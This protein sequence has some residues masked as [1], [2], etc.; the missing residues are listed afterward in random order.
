VTEPITEL[1]ARA[2]LE[3]DTLPVPALDGVRA[4]GR[5]LRT[6]RRALPVMAAAAATLIVVA[7]SRWDASGAGGQLPAGPTD[8]SSSTATVG[9]TATP[10]S[11]ALRRDG[12]LELAD[13]GAGGW[14]RGADSGD[15]G[16]TSGA[17]L[18][19]CS[20]G[21]TG[22]TGGTGATASAPGVGRHQ[23]FRGST[24]EGAEWLV[25]EQ[26]VTVT[27]A[28]VPALGAQFAAVASG[29]RTIVGG[30]VVLAADGHL[31]VTGTLLPTGSVG[32]AHGYALAGSTWV[33]LETLPGGAIGQIPLP[34]QAQWLVDITAKAL[35]R[36]TGRP[37]ETVPTPNAAA[38]AAAAKYVSPTAVIHV[39]SG[40]ASPLPVTT[41]IA[42]PGP[43][44]AASGAGGL[45]KGYLRLADLGTRGGWSAAPNDPTDRQTSAATAVSLPGCA[46]A[47][48]RGA[49]PSPSVTGPGGSLIYRGSTT[50]GSGEWI[51]NETVVRLGA[52]ATA[53]ARAQLAAVAGCST[54]SGGFGAG[55]RERATATSMVVGI[56]LADGSTGYAQAWALRGSV[57]VQLDTL[58]GGAA[59][60]APLPGGAPWLEG[61]LDT[62]LA[63]A[64]A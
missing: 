45:P 51:L 54:P 18:P 61:V 37:P 15:S 57:L 29:C 27:A 58:P 47:G 14:V 63:R 32:F 34:G 59:G 12:L 24:P 16:P 31:L 39:Q 53:T 50:G 35:E 9:P 1:F 44:T 28:G 21:G 30:D 48:G 36:A 56:P 10:P 8:T 43:G 42:V 22:G 40:S 23:M 60:G 55:R 5:Q 2:E 46:A 33:S 7:V 11:G 3:G 20:A 17:E 13:L 19:G 26:V 49:G 62:A 6:R 64:A 52:A 41:T 38:Q 25:N 4:R